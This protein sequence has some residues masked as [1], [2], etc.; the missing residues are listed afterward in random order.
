MAHQ[1]EYFVAVIRD[2][3]GDPE[4]LRLGGQSIRE[5]VKE[6]G[7]YSIAIFDGNLIKD[8]D[9]KMDLTKL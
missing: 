2:T 6:L 8:F 9:S 1:K 4:V 5:L 3:D 7:E